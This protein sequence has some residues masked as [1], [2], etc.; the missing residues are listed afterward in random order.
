MELSGKCIDCGDPGTDWRDDGNGCEQELCY[1]CSHNRQ[2]DR[3]NYEQ[4]LRETAEA[5]EY[6]LYRQA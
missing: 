4:E 3:H 2:H 6:R 5:D 1:G